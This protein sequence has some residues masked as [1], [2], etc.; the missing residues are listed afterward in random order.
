MKKGTRGEARVHMSTPPEKVYDMVSDG[1]IEVQDTT[2]VKHARKAPLRRKRELWR[3]PLLLT[4]SGCVVMFHLSNAAVL[5]FAQMLSP[6]MIFDPSKP[7]ARAEFIEELDGPA[8]HGKEP[9]E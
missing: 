4:F 9:A 7:L 8:A 3:D 6:F 1:L 2:V 5:P